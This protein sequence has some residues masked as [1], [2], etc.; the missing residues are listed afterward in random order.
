FACDHHAQRVEGSPDEEGP[1]RPVP[2]AGD[3]KGQKQ[4]PVHVESPV[5]VSSERN[6][7]VV[8]EPGGKADVPAR[9]EIA[10]PGGEVGIVEVQNQMETHEL[11][12]AAGH[13]RVTAEVEENSARAG[14]C[15]DRNQSCNSTTGT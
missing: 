9:P 6:I 1:G 14:R 11:R 15:P 5:F 12:D 2:D 13:V 10:Q 4:I 8:P 7:D 3:E